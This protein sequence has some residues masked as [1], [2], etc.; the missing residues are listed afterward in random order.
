MSAVFPSR[1][2]VRVSDA[3]SIQAPVPRSGIDKKADQAV[4]AGVRYLQGRTLSDHAWAVYLFDQAQTHYEYRNLPQAARETQLLYLN[5]LLRF[6]RSVLKEKGQ[7]DALEKLA[8]AVY[9]SEFKPIPA[10]ED[11]EFR[12][13]LVSIVESLDAGG[14]PSEVRTARQRL[15]NFLENGRNPPAFGMSF[16]MLLPAIEV[17]IGRLH[18][19]GVLAHGQELDSS[20]TE[21]IGAAPSLQGWD[22]TPKRV[23]GVLVHLGKSNQKIVTVGDGTLLYTGA[24]NRA[25]PGSGENDDPSM[26]VLS[27]LRDFKD[28]TALGKARSV[29]RLHGAIKAYRQAGSDPRDKTSSHFDVYLLYRNALVGFLSHLLRH[30]AE[31]LPKGIVEANAKKILA[32]LR[33]ANPRGLYYALGHKPQG[34]TRKARRRILAFL[35]KMR[36]TTMDPNFTEALKL[37]KNSLRGGARQGRKTQPSI[38]LPEGP[39][40]D[41]PDF[42][43]N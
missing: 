15:K 17:E 29:T 4:Q 23:Q 18:R 22:A 13:H 34:L 1:P 25:M 33:G 16:T 26:L 38:P 32:Y 19:E 3:V 31:T 43:L 2:S 7:E 6:L 42:K 27:A 30:P 11:A 40:P 39:L 10:L 36:P 14:K 5:S 21:R 24:W 37:L 20:I 35:K 9:T 41:H 8:D 28:P 12:S